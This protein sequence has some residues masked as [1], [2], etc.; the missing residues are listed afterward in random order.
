MGKLKQIQIAFD[1]DTKELEKYYYND[2]WRNAYRDMK[3]FFIENDFYHLQ[4][5]VYVSNNKL[6][7]FKAMDL[8]ERLVNKH[9][10]LNLC[11]RDCSITEL[12]GR[13]DANT[14]FNKDYKMLTIKERKEFNERFENLERNK[15]K[16][17]RNE[18]LKT[19]EENLEDEIDDELD[20]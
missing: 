11:V 3:D 9:P 15:E 4:G 13:Y 16:T 17:K 2:S 1:I 10:Y 7:H 20:L 8:L 6:Q 14:L 19:E 18:N 12:D 5:S